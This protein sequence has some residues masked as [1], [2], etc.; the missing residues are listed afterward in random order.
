MKRNQLKRTLYIAAAASIAGKCEVN[1][2][3]NSNHPSS[4]CDS[5]ISKY[6]C[7][8]FPPLQMASLSE[9]TSTSD[10]SSKPQQEMFPL[11]DSKDS[12]LSE[13]LGRNLLGGEGRSIHCDDSDFPLLMS[14]TDEQREFDLKLGKALDT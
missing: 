7:N 1:A 9:E 3:V 5:Q 10:R 12:D 8:D 2:F 14:V 6:N 4:K 13:F 11:V